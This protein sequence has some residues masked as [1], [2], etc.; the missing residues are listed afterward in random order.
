M[1][2]SDPPPG[3]PRG[4]PAYKAMFWLYPAETD[5]AGNP[6]VPAGPPGFGLSVPIN[7]GPQ[8]AAVAPAGADEGAEAY[9][10]AL[11]WETP[12]GGGDDDGEAA[13]PR[14]MDLSDGQPDD[15]F[16]RAGDQEA[17]EGVAVRKPVVILFSDDSTL[18]FALRLRDV[19]REAED[20]PPI[21]LV[22]YLGETALSYRQMALLLPEGPA[23]SVGPKTLTSMVRSPDIA[24]IITSRVYKPLGSAIRP[25]MFR[26]KA[27]RP[28]V[29]AFQGGLDFFPENGYRHRRYCDAIFIT[30]QSSIETFH[31]L[32]IGDDASWQEVGFG[33]PS[34]LHPD[35]A[36]A[37][38]AQRRDIFFYTQALSPS[39]RRGRLHVL[40]ALASMARANPD[41]TV[42]IKL[43]HLPNENQKHLHL[44]KYD[45]PGLMAQMTDLPENLKITACT[46][47]ES[48]ETAA[49][50]ITCTSTA[51][52]DVLRA[53]IPT[54]VYLDFVDNY[55]DPL[56]EPMREVFEGS[57]VI[58]SLEDLLHLRHHDPDPE[59]LADMLCPRDL[60]QRLLDAVARFETRP[61]QLTEAPK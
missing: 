35:G 51:A 17:E 50:G 8:G 44:E 61:F 22:W 55:R 13:N 3:S 48:L 45:Y 23:Y 31:S 16:H 30:P 2:D 54:M 52:I 10:E 39:T 58:T 33:H 43:R 47:D 32:R 59:W 29:I 38:L 26:L 57:K 49:L 6:L 5:A 15:G 14:D 19:L 56:V 36:P 27:N 28:C 60:G 40:R 1:T 24:A 12:E 42:W 11:E 7:A 25:V 46:M 9:D 21:D 4:A 18:F 41:R 20:P 34:F 53:G 37:D